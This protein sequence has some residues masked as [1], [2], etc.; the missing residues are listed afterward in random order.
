VEERKRGN[1]AQVALTWPRNP[2][3]EPGAGKAAP[4]AGRGGRLSGPAADGHTPPAGA[5]HW[6]SA[7]AAATTPPRGDFPRRARCRPPLRSPSPAG[8]RPDGCPGRAAGRLG[9]SCPSPS[10]PGQVT[11]GA[12]T[13]VLK[14]PL[15]LGGGGSRSLPRD[16]A[17]RGLRAPQSPHPCNGVAPLCRA[18][19]V[20]CPSTALL[21]GL[22]G[23][24]S[25]LG[26]LRPAPP[27]SPARTRRGIA[28]SGPGRHN[29]GDH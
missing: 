13:R 9:D 23:Q 18:L 17:N 3:P 28:S 4:G 19:R 20:Q 24:G 16:R 26:V 1:S 7:V 21:R 8:K 10:P 15:W 11:C 27:H 25:A 6:S 14:R 2:H 29:P 12:T 22:R 5:A